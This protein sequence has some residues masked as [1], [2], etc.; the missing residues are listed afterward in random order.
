MES[1]R[2]CDCF[3]LQ[4]YRSPSEEG[5]LLESSLSMARLGRGV[6]CVAHAVGPVEVA[7][8]DLLFDLTASNFVHGTHD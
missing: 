4:G 3:N 2:F 8:G 7:T 6:F 5:T 1:G